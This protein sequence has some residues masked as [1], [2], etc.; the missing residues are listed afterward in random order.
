MKCSE[1]SI[2]FKLTEI[3]KLY[4]EEDDLIKEL[5]EKH[6]ERVKTITE[7]IRILQIEADWHFGK[8]S[9]YMVLR[10]GG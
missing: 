3:H 9:E 4:K 8:I 2:A 7:Q 5:L 6:E 10:N 1:C